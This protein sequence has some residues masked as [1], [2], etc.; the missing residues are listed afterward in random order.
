[1]R[2]PEADKRFA[3]NHPGIMVDLMTQ[4]FDRPIGNQINK[5]GVD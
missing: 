2:L 1:M 3:R 4:Q 5:A